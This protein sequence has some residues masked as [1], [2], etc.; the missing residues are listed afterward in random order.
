MKVVLLLLSIPLGCLLVAWLACVVM[1][2]IIG[3]SAS[4]AREADDLEHSQS[5]HYLDAS[6]T[7][8][9][10]LEQPQSASSLS[11]WGRDG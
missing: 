4:A 1:L 11:A 6:A 7:T 10:R 9:R 8:V 2:A 3:E 5:D